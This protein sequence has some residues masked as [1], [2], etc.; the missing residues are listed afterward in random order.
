MGQVLTGSGQWCC[1]ECRRSFS[2]GMLALLRSGREAAKCPR[3]VALC[4]RSL[5][6]GFG[7]LRIYLGFCGHF[8]VS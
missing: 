2:F 1:N 5:I 6:R 7:V 3:L 4:F 8:A